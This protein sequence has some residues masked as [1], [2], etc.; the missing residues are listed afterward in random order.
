VLAGPVIVQHQSTGTP[1]V[2]P[3][4]PIPIRLELGTA[5]RVLLNGTD[6]WDDNAANA[7]A[8]WTAVVPILVQSS[9]APNVV[10]WSSADEHLGMMAATTTKE[11]ARINGRLAIVRTTTMLNS[12]ACWD[13][14]DGPQRSTLCHEQWTVLL[15]VRRVVLHE[16]G[17]VLGLE[18]PDEGGQDV[19]AVM[20]DTPSDL[21]TLQADDEA[22]IHV[23]YPLQ[24]VAA[25]RQDVSAAVADGG[26]G[27]GGGCAMG[28]GESD[29]M[30]ALLVPIIFGHWLLSCLLSEESH[31]QASHQGVQAPSPAMP[32]TSS[33][34]SMYGELATEECSNTKSQ[35]LNL[36]HVVARKIWRRHGV[37]LL[38]CRAHRLQRRRHLRGLLVPM[39][40]ISDLLQTARN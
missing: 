26:H 24:P 35:S 10:R 30:M 37:F 40:P 12:D 29:A 1:L 38:Q 15:D 31:K 2:W 16:L 27:G 22:G 25:P 34:S 13:A 32:S 9:D 14:Y 39:A 17:H 5:G 4:T 19:S 18:H 36:S 20:N 11:F 23:L 28:T 6:S 8:E 21:D 3:T 7:L 33:R